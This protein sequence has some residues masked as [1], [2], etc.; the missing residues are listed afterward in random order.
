MELASLV[1]AVAR[2]LCNI[3]SVDWKPIGSLLESESL[4]VATCL[5]SASTMHLLVS[6]AM[7]N[8]VDWKSIGSLLDGYFIDCEIVFRRF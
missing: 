5:H 4:V 1:F 2:I 8:S 7:F 6:S 3:N